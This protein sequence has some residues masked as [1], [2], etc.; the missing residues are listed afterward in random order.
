MNERTHY[1]PWFAVEATVF[2]GRT[3]RRLQAVCGEVIDRA[4]STHEPTCA[5]CQA[6]LEAD[7]YAD[8][9]GADL[10][11]TDEVSQ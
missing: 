11:G 1:V 5:A 3:A 7:P 10:F 8:K 2:R 9:T 6:Y 4:T